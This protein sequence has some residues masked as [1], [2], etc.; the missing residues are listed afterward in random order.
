MEW[1]HYVL[2]APEVLLCSPA[3]F[4]VTRIA[5]LNQGSLHT[6]YLSA[7]IP[8]H[9]GGQGKGRSVRSSSGSSSGGALAAGRAPLGRGR[10]SSSER[11]A[12][13]AAAL[14]KSCGQAG[15][16]AGGRAG[17]RAGARRQ[18]L[19]DPCASPP[20]ALQACTALTTVTT[21]ADG[22]HIQLQA[23]LASLARLSKVLQALDACLA[24]VEVPPAYDDTLWSSSVLPLADALLYSRR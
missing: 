12:T 16:Q 10:R 20:L 15:G 3:V 1:A 23:V 4:R 24:A 18:L 17:G 14:L 19:A 22:Q 5:E 6:S 8:A 21:T 2:Q 9:H 11:G 7:E 13:G